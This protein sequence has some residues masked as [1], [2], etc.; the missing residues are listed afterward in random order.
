MSHEPERGALSI[1]MHREAAATVSRTIVFCDSSEA[2][3][4][5]HDGAPCDADAPRMKRSLALA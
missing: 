4:D 3:F 5:Y 2:R 1:C